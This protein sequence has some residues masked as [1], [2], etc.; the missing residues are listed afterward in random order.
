TWLQ[1]H[2]GEFQRLLD[3]LIAGH[4]TPEQMQVITEH[5]QHV[6]PKRSWDGSPAQ[7]REQAARGYEDP[8]VWEAMRQGL[9]AKGHGDIGGPPRRH[10]PSR[11][12]QRIN[13]RDPL[14]GLYWELDQFLAPDGQ[15]RLRKCP[16]CR[17]Y[18][19]QATARRQ[20]Y[21]KTSCQQKANPTKAR[22]N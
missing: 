17:R 1:E 2:Q 8:V 10:P 5:L 18:F 7:V 21:C 9:L 11:Y 4:P 12:I 22:K 13:A 16:H 15:H 6:Q 3:A 20:T 14:D 19:V